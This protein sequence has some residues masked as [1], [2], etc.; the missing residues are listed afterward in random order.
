MKKIL[1]YC[2]LLL[3]TSFSSFGQN[4]KSTRGHEHNPWY[5]NTDTT[6]L[7]VNNAEWKKVLSPDLYAVAREKDT[8]RPFTG[9][10]WKSSTRGTYYCA[11]CGNLLFRSDA[12]F[13]SSC[14]WPSFYEPSR[15]TAVRYHTDDSNGMQRTEVRCGRC[16]SHLGHIFDDGPP[17]TRKRFCMNSV[18]LDFE[19]DTN[20]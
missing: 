20:K 1:I 16:D 11:V 14:G 7:A 13:A 17:P 5:S 8:E 15:K 2:S 10:Y 9:A 12:K 4:K 18:S 6:K 3:L 19:P